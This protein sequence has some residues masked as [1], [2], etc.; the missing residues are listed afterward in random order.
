MARRRIRP[1]NQRYHPITPL[2]AEEEDYWQEGLHSG[3][4][5]RPSGHEL[6]TPLPKKGKR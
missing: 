5:E 6:V 2:H 4:T 3:V 1:Q